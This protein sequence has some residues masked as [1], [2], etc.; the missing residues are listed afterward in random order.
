MEA[1]ANSPGRAASLQDLLAA[2]LHNVGADETGKRLNDLEHVARGK[3]T[4]LVMGNAWR[5]A[6]IEHVEVQRDIDWRFED[7]AQHLSRA[8]GYGRA[9]TENTL[10]TPVIEGIVVLPRNDPARNYDYVIRA[11][12]AQFFNQLRHQRFVPC[13]Q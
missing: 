1:L 6:R 4:R 8:L 12:L 10:H 13:G 11:L 3:P 9:R 7:R 5:E 2:Q